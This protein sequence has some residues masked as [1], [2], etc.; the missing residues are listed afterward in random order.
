MLLLFELTFTS[1]W[2]SVLRF[3]VIL[4][5]PAYSTEYK[6]DPLDIVLIGGFGMT[7]VTV[8]ESFDLTMVAEVATDVVVADVVVVG[9][10]AETKCC[11]GCL[12]M[13]DIVTVGVL[14]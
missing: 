11:D 4:L 3:I 12:F 9:A 2:A 6:A 5:E 14:F 10:G 7:P 8:M 13:L 1:N